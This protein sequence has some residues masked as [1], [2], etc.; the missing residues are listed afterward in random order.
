MIAVSSL[1]I[2]MSVLLV[3]RKVCL[4]DK[5]REGLMPFSAGSSTSKNDDA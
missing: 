5:S 1:T 2:Q 4:H 3:R